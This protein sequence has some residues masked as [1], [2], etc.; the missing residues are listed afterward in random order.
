MLCST[1]NVYIPTSQPVYCC[2][3][4]TFCSQLCCK[5]QFKIIQNKDPW[6]EYP[7]DWTDILNNNINYE[8]KDNIEIYNIKNNEFHVI[9]NIKR[10][11]SKSILILNELDNES[12]AVVYNKKQENLSRKLMSILFLN[13]IFK[14]INLISCLYKYKYHALGLLLYISIFYLIYKINT[15]Y[16]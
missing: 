2:I 4:K 10:N 11:K 8:K 5:K 9:I 12:N 14:N 13:K 15:I 1:C 7:H 6:F 16:N 3:D